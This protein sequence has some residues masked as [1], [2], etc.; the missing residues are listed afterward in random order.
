ML[1]LVSIHPCSDFN[2]RTTRFYGVAASIDAGWD[3]FVPF[4]SDFDLVT[5]PPIYTQFLIDGS[6]AALKLKIAMINELMSATANNRQPRQYDLPEWS[7]FLK[8]S[9]RT[10]QGTNPKKFGLIFDKEENQMIRSRKFVQ[11]LDKWYGTTWA[12][13]NSAEI[14]FVRIN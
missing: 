3:Y 7:I 12:T 10:F 9:L 11:L 14:I 13:R 6:N 1:D 8:E 4:M 2:G 5:R